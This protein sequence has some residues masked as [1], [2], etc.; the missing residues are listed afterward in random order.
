MFRFLSSFIPFFI[1]LL[2]FALDKTRAWLIDKFHFSFFSFLTRNGFVSYTLSFVLLFSL[3]LFLNE[4]SSLR[5]LLKFIFLYLAFLLNFTK[6]G[7]VKSSFM[8]E[9]LVCSLKAF[10]FEFNAL[11]SMLVKRGRLLLLNIEL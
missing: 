11:K 10:K 2:V 6:L 4:P 7:M 8:N 9:S 3:S 1:I 5:T